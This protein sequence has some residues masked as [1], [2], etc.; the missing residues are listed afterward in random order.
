MVRKRTKT[1]HHKF[2]KLRKKTKKSRYSLLRKEY[3]IQPEKIM[4]KVWARMGKTLDQRMLHDVYK[5]ID[6]FLLE[7]L[8][9]DKEFHLNGFGTL[10]IVELDHLNSEGKIMVKFTPDL[11][12]KEKIKLLQKE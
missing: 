3:T 11:K 5:I 2:Q 4:D 8:I 6:E 1:Q 10:H 12:L 9:Y 7:K